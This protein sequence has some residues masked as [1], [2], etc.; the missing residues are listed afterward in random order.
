MFRLYQHFVILER[1]DIGLE[2]D[3]SFNEGS[4][5]TFKR[6]EQSVMQILRGWIQLL[7]MIVLY[8]FG[9]F[10]F[11][12]PV[13]VNHY[14]VQGEAIGTVLDIDPSVRVRSEKTIVDVRNWL[15]SLTMPVLKAT[16]TYDIETNDVESLSLFS[17]NDSKEPRIHLNGERIIPAIGQYP[18]STI[19]YDNS[20]RSI[21]TK[22]NPLGSLLGKEQIMGYI[23]SNTLVNGSNTLS[24][25]Q[26][27]DVQLD[28]NHFTRHYEI[29]LLNPQWQ[30][31][32]T[33]LLRAWEVSTELL[34]S[35]AW[36]VRSDVLFERD[37]DVVSFQLNP[38]QAVLQV[39]LIPPHN[40][41][42]YKLVKSSLWLLLMVM[43][44]ITAFMAYVAG[45]FVERTR[46]PP[47]V[48]MLAVVV[49]CMGMDWIL[50]KQLTNYL[51]TE[52]LLN[53]LSLRTVHE[54]QYN[55]WVHQFYGA[56]LTALVACL[57]FL[58]SLGIDFFHEYEIELPVEPVETEA[59]PEAPEVKLEEE[60][61]P[62][63]FTLLSSE[64]MEDEDEIQQEVGT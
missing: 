5:K 38:S 34:I 17:L 56:I 53:H 44:V 4:D 46:I 28:S 12:Q 26:G 21:D 23:M 42:L 35:P 25:E 37:G 22:D 10:A 45:N 6:V 1:E 8:M 43:T 50:S 47:R 29:F 54:I 33:G 24:L 9:S 59:E 48:M 60:I 19:F 13:Y 7:T 16:T 39:E 52:A 58:R 49:L 31:Q 41:R 55:H 15:P 61:A 2:T 18:I 36:T 64:P 30:G 32:K 40:Q 63:E 62:P 51:E 14:V 20:F 27:F 11:A 3:R 57:V